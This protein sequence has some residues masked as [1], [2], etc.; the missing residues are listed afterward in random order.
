MVRVTVKS[1]LSRSR[2]AGPGPRARPGSGPVTQGRGRV[3]RR[4]AERDHDQIDDSEKPMA[5]RGPGGRG[6]EARLTLART[7]LT[8]TT[9]AAAQASRDSVTPSQR[10]LASL[11]LAGTK[12]E[13]R[14]WPGLGSTVT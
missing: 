11:R 12:P 13:G 10:L 6:S 8:R 3:C 4:K 1:R 9:A 5:R 14:D 7:T 2:R